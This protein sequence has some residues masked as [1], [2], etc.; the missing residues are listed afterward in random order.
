[1]EISLMK[2]LKRKSNG[3]PQASLEGQESSRR[4][5]KTMAGQGS[6]NKT[7]YLLT[8]FSPS[9]LGLAEKN[10][11]TTSQIRFDLTSSRLYS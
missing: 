5:L 10:H 8:L 1:M 2:R 11:T 4:R 3:A 9:G 6:Q 7:F